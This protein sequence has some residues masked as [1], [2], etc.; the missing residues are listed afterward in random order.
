M[1]TLQ[2]AFATIFMVACACA[3]EP[4]IADRL[5]TATFVPPPSAL[6][7]MTNGE[8]CKTV[9]AALANPHTD[10][11]RKDE[12]ISVGQ[13]HHCPNQMMMPPVARVERPLSPQ[14]WCA[15]AFKVLGNPYADRFL[16]AATL[17]KARNRGCLN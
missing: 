9:D 8:W 10:P 7:S 12:Y 11:A 15:N 13:A 17:E 1:K 14:E 6:G 3:G 2:A 5:S 4:S 16:K